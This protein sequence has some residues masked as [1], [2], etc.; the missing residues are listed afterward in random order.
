MRYAG[1]QLTIFD[2]NGNPLQESL[3]SG[4]SSTASLVTGLLGSN[5]FPSL[6]SNLVVPASSIHTRA[7]A[8]NAP[9][10]LSSNSTIASLTVPLL[11]GVS[12]TISY[13]LSGSNYI[14]TQISV[15]VSKPNFTATRT[16]KFANV[17]WSQNVTKDNARI[18]TGSTMKP[19]SSVATGLSTKLPAVPADPAAVAS[20]STIYDPNCNTVYKNLGGVQNIALVHGLFDN[21]CGWLRM[22][23]WINQDFR[24]N[25][26]LIP[27]LPN[28]SYIDTVQAPQLI[29]NI[30]AYGGK[31]YILAGHSQGGLVSRY[32]AQ[33]YQNTFNPVE[34]VITIDTPNHGA[35]VTSNLSLGLSQLFNSFA[36]Q[37]SCDFGVDCFIYSLL[38]EAADGYG[39]FS[40]L[41]GQSWVQLEPGSQFLTKLNSPVTPENFKQAGIVG[42]TDQRWAFIRLASTEFLKCNPEDNCGERAVAGDLEYIYDAMEWIDDSVDFWCFFVCDIGPFDDD[43]ALLDSIDSTYNG[44]ID[45]LGNT[46]CES[47]SDAIVQRSSQLYPGS[48]ARN[49]EIQ[50]ADS[51]VAALLSDKVH[52]QLYS[53]LNDFHV[54]TQA[55]CPFAISSPDS[56]SSSS[57]NWSFN[58]T[59]Q[60]G[61]LW[62]AVSQAPWITVNTPNGTAS[63]TIN[64]TVAA[65]SSNVPRT[66]SINVGNGSSLHSFTIYQGGP[67]TFTL[68]P[69]PEIYIQPTGDNGAI[70]V[71]TYMNC[72]WSAVSNTTSWLGV[73][74]GSG[75]TGSGSF[76]WTAL[77]NAGVGDRTGFINVMGTKLRVMDGS[78]VG[79]PGT[80]TVT[81]SGSPQTLTYYPCPPQAG[82]C[83]VTIPETGNVYVT[84]GGIP[85]STMYYGD[86]T[87]QQIAADLASRIN[88][89]MLSPVEATV[90]GD[91]ITLTSTIKGQ[92]TNFTLS[93]S[94]SFDPSCETSASGSTTCFST[95]AFTPIASDSQLT[96]G[97]D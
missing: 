68:S 83:S 90:S 1:G 61:C 81:I 64:F 7:T 53:A 79:T 56:F 40:E 26:E 15:P 85:F 41:T 28:E 42:D 45:C 29:S 9:L 34:G 35:N 4:L 36:Q 38:L 6:S 48:N 33:Q 78:P 75:G 87:A 76:N 22:A 27:S 82:S 19:L 67:C 86:E 20:A 70:Q 10:T 32:A 91:V 93:T 17:N 39:A 18:A 54:L 8:M 80:A 2:R 65:N 47:Q 43:T 25:N 50:G 46:N 60:T 12:K 14:A 52:S 74:A 88:E 89:P 49:Y 58:L 3:P 71:T 16:I 94:E 21:S 92:A 30:N 24:F 57:V 95:P 13:T 97:T 77:P 44:L 37:A 66:G 96:G 5:P 59:T 55:S 69:G 23:N 63:G 51:H 84:I 62:S 73:S 31:N 11:S 72:P